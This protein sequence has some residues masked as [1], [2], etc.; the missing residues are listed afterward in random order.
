MLPFKRQQTDPFINQ[1]LE[2]SINVSPQVSQ[3]AVEESVAQKARDIE[4]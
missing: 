2:G 1:I 4:N 3:P